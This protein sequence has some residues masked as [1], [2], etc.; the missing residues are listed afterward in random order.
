MEAKEA[1]MEHASELGSIAARAEQVEVASAEEHNQTIRNALSN[2][3][4]VV[5]W[6][7]FFALS[8]IGWGFD[9]QVNGAMISVPQFRQNF[10][11]IYHGE[12]VLSASWQSAFNVISSVG[13]FAG[14]FLCS[15]LA[16]RMGRRAALGVGLVLS[17]AGVFGEVFANTNGAF[18]I[19]KMILGCGLG[20]YLT[21]G[22]LYCSEVC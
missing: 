5:W 7:F 10:G 15:W 11:Y 9:A 18:L 2:N 6:C 17:A 4:R 19:G 13:Q 8:S 21:I 16:D 3:K 22:P 20:F 14:G 12:P 1:Y